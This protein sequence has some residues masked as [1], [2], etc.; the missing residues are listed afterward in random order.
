MARSPSNAKGSARRARSAAPAP[1]DGAERGDGAA[2][3]GGAPAQA[4]ELR[5]RGQRTLRK[6]LDAG[7][8]VFAARG[9]HAARVD[10]V[11]KLAKTSHGTFY[12]YFTNKEDLFR[13]LT[14][15]VADDMHALAEGL[16]P[17][18]AGDAG[19]AELQDWIG[20]FADLYE[21]YGPVIRAWTEAEI[22]SDE[23]GRLGE[24]VLAR[25]TRVLTDRIAQVAP[26]DLDPVV[27]A[28]AI[29][30]MLERLN[31]YVGSGQV[32]IDRRRMV[33]TLARVT[34]AAI[35]GNTSTGRRD[36]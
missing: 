8:Q 20:R 6:L 12:L 31:Y 25:F 3:S 5:A 36:R 33:A 2:P 30:A 26:A 18:R 4:R 10:D 13:A 32:A 1:P 7:V 19:R 34:H 15:E 23:L 22:S 9:Y 28:L 29:V 17:L 27:A 11:V 16:G 24:D 21:H 14:A 35:F